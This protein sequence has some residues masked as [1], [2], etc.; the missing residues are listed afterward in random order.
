M[1]IKSLKL[2]YFSPTGTTKRV[3]QSIAKGLDI[4][5]IS[6]YDITKPKARENSIETTKDELLIVAVPVYMGR[7]PA[8]ISNYLNSIKAHKTPTVC[9]VVYG[10]RAYDDALLELSNILSAVGCIPVSGAAFIGEHS[11]S[12]EELPIAESRPNS[13]DLQLAEDFGK[14]IKDKLHST[15]TVDTMAKLHIPG[16]YP[17]GGSTELWSIDFI[18][19]SNS[20]T[21]DGVCAE[22]CPA[23]AI[24]TTNISIIDK[25]KCISCCAC[26]KACPQN[27]RTIKAGRVKDAAIRLNSLFHEPKLPEIF[28]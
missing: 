25:E 10:N 28:F 5:L 4:E 6:L 19:I 13:N 12:S 26:I 15:Q 14:R 23:G 11:F 21:N 7:V 22:V 18:A 16:S 9:V 24:N 17:Y 8:I 20:C 1:I 3:V 2:V 27:A